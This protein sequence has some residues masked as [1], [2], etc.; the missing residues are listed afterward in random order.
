MDQQ[1]RQMRERPMTGQKSPAEPEA[2]I[3]WPSSTP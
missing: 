3:M 2:N 1:P